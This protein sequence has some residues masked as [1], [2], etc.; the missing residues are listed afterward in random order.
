M[1]GRPLMV[2]AAVI[3]V[4]A[5]AVGVVLATRGGSKGLPK[6]TVSKIT[7]MS[8]EGCYV[9]LPDAQAVHF[10]VPGYADSI[11]AAVVGSG[12]VGVVL[13][14]QLDESMCEW[15]VYAGYLARH[16]YRALAFTF[17]DSGPPDDATVVAA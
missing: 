10:T 8:T 7:R 17:A 6:P 16:G 4:A 3:V 5:I 1:R 15:S 2:G 11:D 9:G 14:H 13:A 12:K